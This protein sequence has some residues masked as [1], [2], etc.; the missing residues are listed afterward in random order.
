M[1]TTAI[2]KEI[3]PPMVAM[4]VGVPSF[5][6]RA[7]VASGILGEGR[8]E[9]GESFNG[10]RDGGVAS[11]C[12]ETAGGGSDGGSSAT[13]CAA[14][15]VVAA[16]T[17]APSAAEAAAGSAARAVRAETMDVEASATWMTASMMT[18]PAR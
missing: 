17:L 7:I 1:A 9:G 10:I 12:D 5:V 16:V 8:V 11:V 18:E 15:G 13:S 3:T 14:L 2:T 6:P 4:K